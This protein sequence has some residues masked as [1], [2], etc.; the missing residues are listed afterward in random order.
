MLFSWPHPSS[1]VYP[2]LFFL[3]SPLL[4]FSTIRSQTTVFY[5]CLVV[6]VLQQTHAH[7]RISF[8]LVLP[9]VSSLASLLGRRLTSFMISPPVPFLFSDMSKSFRSTVILLIP[10][11]PP[12]LFLPWMIARPYLLS[13]TLLLPLLISLLHLCLYLHPLLLSSSVVL[14]F[15]PLLLGSLNLLCTWLAQSTDGVSPPSSPQ[16]SPS[17]ASFSTNISS[18]SEPTSYKQASLDPRWLQAMNNE[19]NALEHN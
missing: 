2:S 10:F 9:S 4:N 12:S 8:H 7:T 6:F 1:I 14:T 19:L 18:I 5:G 15:V 17:Y 11:H 13:L 16:F 3:G